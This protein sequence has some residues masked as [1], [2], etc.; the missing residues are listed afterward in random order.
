[1]P[2]YMDFKLNDAQAHN[3]LMRRAVEAGIDLRVHAAS[4]DSV[5]LFMTPKFTGNSAIR[6][7]DL[8]AVEFRSRD[9]MRAGLAWFRGHVP[10]FERAWIMD[11]TPQ[12]GGH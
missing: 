7:A 8:T 6:V 2:R 5:T 3:E 9:A 4:D 11:T 12:I 1:M 10:G